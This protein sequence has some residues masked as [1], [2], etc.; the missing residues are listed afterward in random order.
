MAI[1]SLKN[2]TFSRSLLIG[3]EFYEPPS[4]NLIQTYTVGAG[5]AANVQFN[6]IPSGYSHLQIRGIYSS[7]H[8]SNYGLS[9][10]VMQFNS[11]TGSNYRFHYIQAT[12]AA[13]NAGDSGATSYAYVTLAQNQTYAAN[14][15][16]GFVVDILD[17][18]NTNKYKTVRALGGYDNNGYSNYPGYIMYDSSLWTNTNAISSIL[19]KSDQGAASIEQYSR[20]SLY[21]I[22]E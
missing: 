22:S 12:G 9:S 13:I 1:R 15:F 20:F 8:S 6:S 10:C 19:L 16:S 5:G 11:D 4:F 18:S 7:T 17:Y 14:V 3:N 21:G 2:G